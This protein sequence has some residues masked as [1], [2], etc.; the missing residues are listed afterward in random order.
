[1]AIQSQFY[2]GTALDSRTFPTTKHIATKAHMAVWRQL[3]SDDSWVQM[4]ISDYQLIN[5]SCVLNA[6]L[7]TVTY[8]QLEVRVGDT[9]DELLPSISDIA[10]VASISD[11]IVIVANNADDVVV[12]ADNIVDVNTVS[13]NI[14]D[15]IIT[16]DDIVNINLVADYIRDGVNT[17]NQFLGSSVLKGV[18]YMAS[19]SA[20]A[21]V[22]TI[23]EN[24][25]AFSVESF[26]L[27]DGASIVLENNS[28]YKVI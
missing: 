14:A 24:L 9:P 19:E 3:V 27:L 11:E 15:V 10:L 25:N 7:N 20:P 2:T 26:T 28:T 23:Q 16:A 1:M 22:I 18:Q 13:T 6:L 12:V 8:K 5:N 21:E 4:N 17:N